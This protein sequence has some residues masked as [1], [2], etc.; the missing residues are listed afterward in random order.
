MK[1]EPIDI[2]KF[3]MNRILRVKLTAE[4]AA[5]RSAIDKLRDAGL[6]E[7]FIRQRLEAQ[8]WL[9]K[10]FREL[11]EA[12]RKVV[13]DFILGDEECLKNENPDWHWNKVN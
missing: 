7:G 4:L 5:M 12:S 1:K 10:E 8:L 6:P 3:I 2:G 11:P 13:L 9:T